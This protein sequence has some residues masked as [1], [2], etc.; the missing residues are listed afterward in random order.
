MPYISKKISP[1][2]TAKNVLVKYT[3]R[4]YHRE[5]KPL[6]FNRKRRAKSMRAYNVQHWDVLHWKDD[7]FSDKCTVSLDLEMATKHE[8]EQNTRSQ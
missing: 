1:N 2:R 5:Q 3:I 7:L 6:V 8:E 4:S